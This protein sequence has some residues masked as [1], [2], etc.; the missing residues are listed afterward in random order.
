MHYLVLCRNRSLT[1]GL[2]CQ[3]LETKDGALWPAGQHWF[4]PHQEAV[5]GIVHGGCGQEETVA[6]RGT[7]CTPKKKVACVAISHT[8][9]RPTVKASRNIHPLTPASV[10]EKSDGTVSRWGSG[11]A[12]TT[13]HAPGKGFQIQARM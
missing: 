10:L 12:S 9:D 2:D 1:S 13:S 8:Q 6:L 4:Y 11:H 5:Q 3:G 7:L